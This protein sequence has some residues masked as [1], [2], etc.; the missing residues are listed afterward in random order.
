[1]FNLPIGAHV[2]FLPHSN[3]YSIIVNQIDYSH[4]ITYTYMWIVTTIPC[5]MRRMCFGWSV[6]GVSAQRSQLA[7]SRVSSHATKHDAID[8]R[9][10][11]KVCFALVYLFA[12]GRERDR[13]K[14][15]LGCFKEHVE[16]WKFYIKYISR[17]LVLLSLKHFRDIL[18]FVILI[19]FYLNEFNDLDFVNLSQAKKLD[20][21]LSHF[22]YSKQN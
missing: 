5:L 2:D 22:A 21:D 11:Y 8:S 14:I 13:H 18:Y 10:R 17:L 9:K 20:K 6:G 1:M 19:L 16:L 15:V 12:R 3:L 4:F 7:T